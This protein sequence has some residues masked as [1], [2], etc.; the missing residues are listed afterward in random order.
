MKV[1]EKAQI[2]YAVA[3]AM[4]NEK[5]TFTQRLLVL[6]DLAKAMGTSLDF[7][8]ERFTLFSSAGPAAKQIAQYEMRGNKR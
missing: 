3:G 7:Y 5:F 4:G 6:S 1:S 8:D 2:F